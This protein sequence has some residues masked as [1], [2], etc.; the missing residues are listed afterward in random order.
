MKILFRWLDG[1]VPL[2]SYASLPFGKGQRGCIGKTI[3]EISMMMF[4]I[5]FFSQ[6]HI[7]WVGGDMDYV[8]TPI[9]KPSVPLLF[10]IEPLV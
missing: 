4:I 10:N 9:N 7:S 6:F 1:S 8:T 3:A 5:R 2:N